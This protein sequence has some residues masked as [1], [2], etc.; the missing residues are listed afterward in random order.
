[1]GMSCAGQMRLLTPARLQARRLT[2]RCILEIDVA[3]HGQ[4]TPHPSPQDD[5]AEKNAELRALAARQR[6]SLGLGL[7]WLSLLSHESADEF[8]T[9][10]LA[11]RELKIYRANELSAIRVKSVPD[12]PDALV[13]NDLVHPDSTAAL[14][15][16]FSD[17]LGGRESSS[18]NIMLRSAVDSAYVWCSLSYRM[19]F[20]ESGRPVMAVGVRRELEKLQEIQR[21]LKNIPDCLTPHLLRAGT[22]NLATR[23]VESML[24]REGEQ[25]HMIRDVPLDRVLSDGADSLFSRRESEAYLALLD[26]ERVIRTYEE[27]RRW[28]IGRFRTVDNGMTHP[29]RIAVNVRKDALG[30]LIAHTYVSSCDQRNVWEANADVSAMRD[31]DTQLY[32]HGYAQIITRSILDGAPLETLCALTAIRIVCP[33]DPSGRTARGVALAIGVFLDT[34]CIACLVDDETV[35]AFFPDA[36]SDDAVRQHVFSALTAA[37]ESLADAGDQAAGLIDRAYSLVAETVFGP[38]SSFDP[39][40]A[41][42]QACAAC[43]AREPETG[44]FVAQP[45]PL[46]AAG[47]DN[48]LD[49]GAPDLV[50]EVSRLSESDLRTYAVIT[51]AMLNTNAPI[52]AVNAALRGVGMHYQA[53]RCYLV[54]VTWDNGLLTIPFEWAASG[55]MSIRTRLSNSPASRFPFISRNIS[56]KR[57]VYASRE[58]VLSRS[59]DGYH[60]GDPWR[61]C[62][63]PLMHSSKRSLALCVDSP[64][65]NFESWS[66]ASCV[67]SRALHDWKLFAYGDARAGSPTTSTELGN[68]PES[69]ELEQLVAR[70]EGGLWNSLGVLA[71]NLPDVVERVSSE[72]FTQVLKTYGDVKTA[73]EQQFDTMPVF[74]TSD[75]EFI[76]LFPN[77]SYNAFI[78][79]CAQA[80]MTLVARHPHDVQ[81]GSAWTDSIGN[82][83]S[84]IDEARVIALHDTSPAFAEFTQTGNSKPSLDSALPEFSPLSKTAALSQRFTVFLQ[85]KIDMRTGALVGAEALARVIDEDGTIG[86]PVK[87]VERME[88][89]GEIGTLD[90]FVFDSMLALMSSWR[91]RGYNVPAI[92]SNFSRTTL[93]SPTSLASV[94]AIMS[95][96]PSVPSRLIEMEVTETAIDLGTSTLNDLVSRYRGIGLRVALDDFGSH[97]SNISVLANVRFDTIKLDQSIVRDI[98]GNEVSCALVRNIAEICA[99]QNM[100]CVAEGVESAEQADALTR[101]GCC[102]C[103]GYFYDKP[104]P[105]EL[106]AR[107][108]LVA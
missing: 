83:W 100:S 71:V 21:C 80:R 61:F 23:R 31:Q 6:T 108:Y 1:M 102:Y 51:S 12:V 93:L 8:W 77:S 28:E 69:H 15:E 32:Q 38:S 19:Q 90:Y 62:V 67:G 58:H 53:R 92:S 11:T 63:V 10:D 70:A 94:L 101:E 18:A 87:T 103:Q 75:S 96:Y 54:M 46:L 91:Q 85:P 86:S 45:Q 9:Y 33:D 106:F 68:M 105:P 4:S 13:V 73:L 37:R 52:Q 22:I 25:M 39:D 55:A 104:M 16:F 50:T 24:W 44:V 99:S 79:R 56:A 81:L 43:A 97:Y 84:T 88:Q 107:K 20:D 40:A 89:S 57:P 3:S 35:V 36:E 49:G 27:G 29:I 76:A 26:P 47:A 14:D 65:R 48:D 17:I 64:S 95:R 98:P 42:A 66:L 2:Q 7:T 78:Q 41:V 30:T 59:E 60:T 72:G 5:L 82:A 34:G 74:H